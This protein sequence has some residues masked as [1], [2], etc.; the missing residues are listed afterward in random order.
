MSGETF[1]TLILP[2]KKVE[3]G[4]SANKWVFEWLK[5]LSYTEHSTFKL[6][7]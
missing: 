4:F 1:A 7:T 3:K 2:L 6:V 5:E